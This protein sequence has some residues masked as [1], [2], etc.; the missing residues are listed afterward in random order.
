MRGL[1]P[2]EEDKGSEEVPNFTCEDAA[3]FD[4]SGRLELADALLSLGFVFL[5]GVSPPAPHPDPGLD[6]T[7]DSLCCF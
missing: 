7:S 1:R 5:N 6:P 3:D 4:D 2:G